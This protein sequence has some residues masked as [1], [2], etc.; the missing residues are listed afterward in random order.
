MLFT[1]KDKFEIRTAQIKDEIKDASGNLLV[2]LNL[3]YPDIKCGKKDALSKFAKP[4]YKEFA[5]AFEKYAKTEL[6]ALAEKANNAS[7]D[8]FLPYSAV[9]KYEITQNDEDFVS[10]LQEISVSDGIALPCIERKTQVWERAH[11][12]KCKISFFLPRREL[13]GSLSDKLDKSARKSFDT[14]LFVLREGRLEF[15]M[16]SNQGYSSVTVPISQKKISNVTE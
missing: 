15:F 2:R 9:M 13:D 5:L 7:P 12:S 1:K 6:L 14:S 8:T 16:R 11:G 3:R 10:V 4:F